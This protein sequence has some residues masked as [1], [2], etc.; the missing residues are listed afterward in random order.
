MLYNVSLTKGCSGWSI[1]TIT[2]VACFALHA[3]KGSRRAVDK[4][5]QGYPAQTIIAHWELAQSDSHTRNQTHSWDSQAK[6]NQ[7]QFRCVG[8]TDDDSAHCYGLFFICLCLRLRDID[9]ICEGSHPSLGP[10]VS[11]LSVNSMLLFN[12]FDHKKLPLQSCIFVE[13]QQTLK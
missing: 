8:F 11:P 2:V 12:L 9:S 10:Q 1:Q 3:M 6:A 7:T 13:V 4:K 5:A